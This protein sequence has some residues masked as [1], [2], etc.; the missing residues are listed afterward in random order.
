MALGGASAPWGRGPPPLRPPVAFAPPSS[1]A[2][3]RIAA[4]RSDPRSAFSALPPKIESTSFD[5]AAA[6]FDAGAAASR[7]VPDCLASAQGV[8]HRAAD[9]CRAGT[10]SR[11]GLLCGSSSLS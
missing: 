10:A 4:R 1:P 3:R 11:A 9:A 8:A 6:A 7:K 5:E 2:S